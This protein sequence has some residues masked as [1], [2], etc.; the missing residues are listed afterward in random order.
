MNYAWPMWVLFALVMAT[1]IIS[2]G[3]K[4]GMA[5]FIK[6]FVNEAMGERQMSSLYL[7]VLGLAT[8]GVITAVSRYFYMYLSRKIREK[9]MVS[10]RCDVF[11]RLINLPLGFYSQQEMGDLISRVTNDIRVARQALHSVLTK[12][13]KEPFTALFAVGVM[14]SASVSL[15]VTALVVAPV[16]IFPLQWFAQ[17][18][19]TSKQKSLLKLGNIVESLNQMLSGLR[20]VRIF[21]AEDREQKHFR[22]TNNKLLRRNLNVIH[23][24][25]LSQGMIELVTGLL[26]AGFIFGGSWLVLSPSS[27]IE[28][29]WGGFCTFIA[30]LWFLYQPVRKIT[31]EYNRLMESLAGVR[32]IRELLDRKH[33]AESVPD[34]SKRITGIEDRISIR[35]LS[36]AYDSTPVLRNINLD[37][38]SGDVVALVGPSGAGKSTLMDNIAR[39][40]HHQEGE[41]LV[42]GTPIEEIDLDSYIDLLSIVSQDAYLFNTTVEENIQYGT[43]DADREDVREAAR[44]AHIDEF[45]QS[46]EHGYGTTVGERGVRMSGGQKQRLTIAR[47]ILQDPEL[48][49]LD[50]ATSDLDSHSEQAIQDAMNTLLKDRTC[51]VIAHRLSTILDADKIIVM[52]DGRIIQKGTHDQLLRQDGLYRELCETQFEPEN[53]SA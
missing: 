40:Y 14:F 22:K 51:V 18:V 43:P 6:P 10:I 45:I 42:D 44:M 30:G 32:R 33:L 12:L 23:N 49:L 21:Q 31:K 38:K 48:L 27:P 28:L 34:G 26:L 29:S 37:I 16:I 9:I 19:K 3:S 5:Y 15:T 35:N 2:S 41:M 20:V 11:E 17:R 52:N 36:F 50:E 53:L 47:A 13:I 39:F 8:L 7:I 4:T 46:L 25:A 1:S 24:K